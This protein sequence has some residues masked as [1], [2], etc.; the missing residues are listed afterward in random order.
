[1]AGG[2]K[3]A[4]SGTGAAVLIAIIAALI[5]VYILFLPPASRESLLQG[6]P[7]EIPGVPGVA[8]GQP[9]LL[10]TPGRLEYLPQ[11]EIEHA[12]PSITLYSTTNAVTFKSIS[13]LYAKNAWFDKV[14]GTLSFS[15]GDLPN[16]DK[17]YLSFNVKSGTGRLI[18]LL[19][20]QEV[21]NKEITTLN[22]EPIPLPKDILQANNT[23][24][25]RVSDVGFSFWRSNEYSLEMIRV[26]GQVTDI[27]TREAK[28]VFLV[29][30]PERNNLEQVLMRF[31]PDC[32]PEEAGVLDI[33]L[34]DHS[35]F[36]SAPDCG[37][38]RE[39]EIS[40]T[41]LNQGE[42]TLF[43]KTNRGAYLIDVMSIKSKLR[44]VT[45]PTFYFEVPPAL[46]AAAQQGAANIVLTMEFPDDV[47][48]KKAELYINGHLRGLDTKQ[49]IF[50]L[51]INPFIQ[52]GNNV[53]EIKP[54]T[55]LD[56]VNLKVVVG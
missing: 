53:V 51:G 8:S 20:R 34:N 2:S 7:V 48:Q 47:E 18:I 55:T 56:V 54:K 9:L 49:R 28:A 21:F 30:A 1:M 36:S 40:P 44:E 17:V 19:N 5:V 43:F 46:A 27:S 52:P 23:L 32:K 37:Y 16:T 26:I 24:E 42:N 33:H 14:V 39:V 12:I 35:I 45:F 22:V 11:K 41:L 13:T 6:G 25:F 15:I 29:S 50:T 31:F 3:K 38:L 10:A 4:Q